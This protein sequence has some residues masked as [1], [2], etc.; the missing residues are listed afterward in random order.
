M[1]YHKAS[2]QPKRVA[3]SE[4]RH[5]VL[6][7]A[8]TYGPHI[9]FGGRGARDLRIARELVGYACLS[10]SERDAA[11]TAKGRRILSRWNEMHGAARR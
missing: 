10:G 2:V 5:D 11:I 8:A 4:R 9:D 6:R 3:Y 1:T 7:M